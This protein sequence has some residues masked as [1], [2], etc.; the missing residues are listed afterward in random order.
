MV[1]DGA[2]GVVIDVVVVVGVVGVV[3]DVRDVTHGISPN[4]GY[5]GGARVGA[6]VVAVGE[7]G[8][9]PGG[10]GRPREGP[11]ERGRQQLGRVRGAD[12]NN[13]RA[14]ANTETF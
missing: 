12:G 10:A 6:E 14:A 9:G 1:D 11:V 3:A 7:V 2:V 13:R 5:R 8:R 4:V